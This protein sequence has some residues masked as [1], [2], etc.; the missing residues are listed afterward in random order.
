MPRS[1]RDDAA[2]RIRFYIFLFVLKYDRPLRMSV[3]HLDDRRLRRAVQH[4]FASETRLI[5]KEHVYDISVFDAC[6]AVD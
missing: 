6:A 5:A 4:C 2:G 3:N 1:G